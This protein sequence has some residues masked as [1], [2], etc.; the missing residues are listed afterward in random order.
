MIIVTLACHPSLFQTADAFSLKWKVPS[1]LRGGPRGGP[2]ADLKLISVDDL[3]YDTK[4]ITD[5]EYKD[6]PWHD[7]PEFK[8]YTSPTVTAHMDAI[9]SK[10]V[11]GLEGGITFQEV[12]SIMGE[13]GCTA[14][15]LGGE[16]RDAILGITSLDTDIA[17]T[18][19]ADTVAQIAIEHHWNYTHTH[20]SSY[21]SLGA[22]S[23][24][25]GLEGKDA[26]TSLDSSQEAHEYCSNTLFWDSLNKA[27][28][29]PTGWGV[30]D[31][32]NKI[33][34]IPPT[35]KYD[36]WASYGAE[37]GDYIK[38]LRTGIS[39]QAPRSITLTLTLTL[40]GRFFVYGN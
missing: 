11:D 40:I 21:I 24:D 18:C 6:T 12:F 28:L 35:D 37:P 14:Y 3:K 2:A 9:L 26:D 39:G 32:L 29:D 23:S 27:I 38:V 8:A 30:Y 22:P 1:L 33:G 34:R 4:N 15:V 36:E 10:Q 19:H 25:T 7:H 20:G 17:F 31:V 13:G 16:V 5:S